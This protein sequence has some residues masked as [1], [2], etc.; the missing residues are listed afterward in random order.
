MVY[1]WH[2]Q[3]IFVVGTYGYSMVNNSCTFYFLTCKCSNVE[4]TLQYSISA[5][6]HICALSMGI[7]VQGHMPVIGNIC[8]GVLLV[9]LLIAGSL[10]E[11][12]IQT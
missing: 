11:V 3:G 5:V 9:T 7:F 1:L 12:N 2:L 4:S 6:G 10:Y 8:V